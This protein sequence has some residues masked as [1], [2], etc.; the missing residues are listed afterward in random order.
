MRKIKVRYLWISV[1]ISFLI[2]VGLIFAVTQTTGVWTNVV[3]VLI[4]IVFIYTTIAI[5]IASTRTFRYKAKPKK[6]VEKVYSFKAFNIDEKLKK[7]GYKARIT[8]YGISLLKVSVPNAYKIVLINNASKY[9]NA[10][11]EQAP[12]HPEKSLEKCQKFIGMEIFLDVNEE[13]LKRIPDFNIQGEKVYYSGCF[14]EE[15]HL[16]CPN[17]IEPSEVFQALFDQLLED[18]E[19]EEFNEMNEKKE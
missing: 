11:E 2:A 12:A 1:A 6:Y 10:E 4:A 8:P 9:F 7:K 3:I 16:I 14:V 13:A 15:E 19:A 5:Q 17:F 18:I